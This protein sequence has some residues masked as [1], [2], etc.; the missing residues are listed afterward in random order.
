[1]KIA[2]VS[3]DFSEY[4]IRHVNEMVEQADVL[5]MLPIELANADLQLIDPRVRFVPFSRPRYR[6]PA[7]QLW[8]MRKILRTVR[9]YN[10]DV[11]HFQN[12]HLYFN[13]AL[14][15]FR[16][17]PFVLT[18]HDPRQH[19]GDNESR[20]TPQWLMDYG[21][22]QADHVIVHAESAVA[23]AVKELG[24][25]SDKVHVIPH[26]AIGQER[27][28]KTPAV[29]SK[30]P[31]DPEILF[32]GRIWGYKGLEYLIKAQPII[33]AEFPDAKFVI[34]GEGDDFKVYQEQMVDPLRFEVHNTWIS[35]EFRAELFSRASIVALPYIEASQSG[36]VPIAY[37]HR[38]PVVATNV[39]GLPDVVDDEKTGILV[40]PR[41]V[42]ALAAALIKLLQDSNL[43]ARMGQ[44][45][46]RK[47]HAE[48]S[49]KVVA[50][51]TLNVY[52]SA[53]KSRGHKVSSFAT[54]LVDESEI[55]DALET[56]SQR[57]I[58]YLQRRFVKSDGGLVGPDPG[59]RFNYRIWRFLKS[60]APDRDWRDNLLYQ[61]A[62]GYWTLLLWKMY[63]A[64]SDRGVK[65]NLE[66]LA[67]KSSEKVLSLQTA[68][69]AWEYPNP[70]WRG[71][72]A[73]VE[74][75]WAS[76]GLMET[77]Q[78]QATPRSELLDAVQKWHSFFTERIGYQDFDGLTAVNYFAGEVD[79]PV[80]NNSA[81]SLRYLARIWQV[82]GDEHYLAKCQGLLDFIK[83][84]QLPS[85]E[86]PYVYQSR[87]MTHFQCF[88]YQ[89]FLFLDVLEYYKI[90]RDEAALGMLSKLAG[91]VST[92]VSPQGFA[93]Y[94]CGCNYRT[95]NYHTAV[96]A[97]ALMEASHLFEVV[98]YKRLALLA[99]MYVVR[100]Q[101]SD[102]SIPHSQGDYG[103]LCDKRKYPRYLAMM[104]LHLLTISQLLRSADFDESKI[105]ADDQRLVAREAE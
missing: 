48:A 26:V 62:Q 55:A 59:V 70:E 6:Q 96:V 65:T 93:Y 8:E 16:R 98:E 64:T 84:A 77:Y 42:E 103:I 87:A 71:R 24:F 94:E 75:I 7:R 52:A 14:S 1:M 61:Q 13:L 100:Q 9:K 49:P 19:P 11:V 67:K 92:G 46:Y 86:V 40:P 23:I 10:P 79:E 35:D 27:P 63:A 78:Q 5:L 25:A 17:Y 41:N 36:V 39:G 101:L 2:F 4:C 34:A 81:L 54:I 44:A 66:D 18:I 22:K 91:F 21:F 85:G 12:G 45:G 32:F 15:L 90:T 73:T 68:Q 105:C 30:D 97:A 74:G 20:R 102:G 28:T 82:T 83:T 80:P 69:G 53:I 104:G 56:S 33:N 60:V 51:K 37:N 31:G 72:V 89:A 29:A 99:I 50:Q 43:R 95:V 3:Y 38:K 58:E 57:I 76:L 47:L 88:Q